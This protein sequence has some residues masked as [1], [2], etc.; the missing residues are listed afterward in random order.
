MKHLYFTLIILYNIFVLNAQIPIFMG[1]EQIIHHKAYTVSYNNVILIPNWV[2]YTLD[3]EMLIEGN[4][5]RKQKFS[6]DPLVKKSATSKDYSKSGY[7]KGHLVPAADMNWNDEVLNECFYYSNICPQYPN[8][9]RGVWASLEKEVRKLVYRKTKVEV[10]AGPIFYS[11]VIKVIV[12]KN[13]VG[14]PDAFFKVI[15][16]NNDTIS[17]IIPNINDKIRYYK[18]KTDIEKVQSLTKCKIRK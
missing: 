7:D 2:H 16:F 4:L 6:K 11:N 1:N 8:F 17:Y 18:Y 5:E 10:Y 13:K 12:H 9:N 3:I 15:I 14:V